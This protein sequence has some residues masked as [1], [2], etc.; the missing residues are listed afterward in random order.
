MQDIY[1]GGK[2]EILILKVGVLRF[3]VIVR[4]LVI[5]IIIKTTFI[6]AIVTNI[7]TIKNNINFLAV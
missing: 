2:I 6:L 5:K 3:K 1:L 4:I 7:K